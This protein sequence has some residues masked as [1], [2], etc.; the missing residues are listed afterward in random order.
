MTAPVGELLVGACTFAVLARV[1]LRPGPH[2]RN[3]PHAVDPFDEFAAG[4]DDRRRRLRTRRRHV[5]PAGIA[6]WCDALAD[7]VRSGATIG[8]ALRSHDPPPGSRLVRIRDGLRRGLPLATAVE[9]AA[10]TAD[11]R[12]VTTVLAA[13]AR[14]GG[15]AAQPLDRVAATL[16]RRAAD[17]AERLTQ[18]SQARLSA[19]VMTLLPGAVLL[20]LVA[21]SPS[22]RA[23]IATPFGAAVVVLGALLNAVGWWWMRR[24]IGARG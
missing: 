13:I 5:G 12:V 1:R 7:D 14:H 20:L 3:A 2:L 8:A 19:L 17:D 18:S 24:L 23:T 6:A 10:H 9:G 22:V 16:R 11:E 4:S 21:T 15:E